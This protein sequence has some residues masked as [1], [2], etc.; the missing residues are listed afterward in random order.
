M[1][2]ATASEYQPNS[3]WNV[4]K[5]LIKKVKMQLISAPVLIKPELYFQ[6]IVRLL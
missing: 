6:F 1:K 4:P 3:V 2:Y 5:N